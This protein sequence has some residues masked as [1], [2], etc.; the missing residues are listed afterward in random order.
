MRS[1]VQSGRSS[2]WSPSSPTIWMC[3]SCCR[4]PPAGGSRW[5]R[6]M[7]RSNDEDARRKANAC[8][9]RGCQCNSSRPTIQIGTD[10]CSSDLQTAGGRLTLAPIYEA[11]KRRGCAEEGECLLV[12]GMPVQFLPAYNPL[13]GGPCRVARDA[14]CG[15]RDPGAATGTSR[16]DHGADG[17]RQGPA[18]V[19]HFHAGSGTG[20]GLSSRRAGTTS[21]HRKVQSMEE[22]DLN[23]ILSGKQRRRHELARLPIEKKLL[24]VVRLQ[25]LAA[26]ILQQRGKTVRCWSA[27]HFPMVEKLP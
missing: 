17:P 25:E 6:S 1:V 22:H 12:E 3:S 16:G 9:L 15:N 2:I 10:V 20:R 14:L 18:A 13:L 11:L 27:G 19:F 5:R 24:A 8:W 26:P 23:Q 7:R 4:K 21:A